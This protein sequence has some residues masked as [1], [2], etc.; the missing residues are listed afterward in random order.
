MRFHRYKKIYTVKLDN[1]CTYM[2]NK[3]NE[4]PIYRALTDLSTSGTPLQLN[5]NNFN[6][7]DKIVNDQQKIESWKQKALHGKHQLHQEFIDREASNKWLSYGNV[8][9]ETEGFMIA[10]QEQII[11][12][13]NYAKYILQDKNIDNSIT[14]IGVIKVM[15]W[16]DIRMMRP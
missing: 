8:F 4:S 7:K 2:L 14:L 11:K 1:L 10:I 15:H 16:S 13:R 6:P 3:A 5:N 9:P 12:T